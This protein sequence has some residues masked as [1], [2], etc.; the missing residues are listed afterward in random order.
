MDRYRA[1]GNPREHAF[2]VGHSAGGG[3]GLLVPDGQDFV[4]NSRVQGI[5]H[6]ARPDAL[7]LMRA[8][9]AAGQ[10]GGSGRLHRH[11]AD[12]RILLL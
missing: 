10:D 8:G 1:G 4:V 2:Q 11:H 5:G 12:S 9:R 6:K 3:E 7:N